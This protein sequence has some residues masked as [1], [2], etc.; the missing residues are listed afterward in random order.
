[1][2][3]TIPQRT[4]YVALLGRPNAGKST[5]LN[6]F[7]GQKLS[8]ITRKPQTTRHRILGIKSLPGAQLLFRDTPGI[9]RAR[10]AI[11][12][13]M[14]GAA[15]SAIADADVV[16]VMVEAGQPAGEEEQLLL[17]FLEGSRARVVVAINKV[18]RV[19]KDAVLP[20]IAEWSERLPGA[21][22]V[23]ISAL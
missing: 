6:R 5:L 18:D 11:N 8:I 3:Q 9:H 7:L 13:A 4:G 10:K 23:P 19:R 21:A 12:A 20:Q 14:T 16:V 17:Q 22:I 15:R 2:T 1:M